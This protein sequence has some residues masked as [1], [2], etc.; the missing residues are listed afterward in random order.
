MN[1]VV[2]IVEASTST[3]SSTPEVI[4]S[5]LAAAFVV[6]KTGFEGIVS[7]DLD[8]SVVAADEKE[9]LVVGVD[10]FLHLYLKCQ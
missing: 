7:I 2:V 1:I 4:F 5:I 10:I 3:A 9:G 6:R 8:T